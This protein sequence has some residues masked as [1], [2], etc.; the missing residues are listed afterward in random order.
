[1]TERILSYFYTVKGCSHLDLLTCYGKPPESF[2]FTRGVV[3]SVHDPEA[4]ADRSAFI[5]KLASGPYTLLALMLTGSP[6][7]AKWKWML[8]FRSSARLIAVNEEAKYFG[9]EIWNHRALERML[10]QRL[11][12]FADY[13]RDS[14]AGM[15]VALLAGLFVAP[16]TVAYLLLYAAGL[17]LRRWLRGRKGAPIVESVQI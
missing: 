13:T 6:V 14:L 1:M 10:L 17:H 5:Q 12:P 8:A 15:L 3:Y 2:D 7:L 4:R 16:F 9:L 11:N